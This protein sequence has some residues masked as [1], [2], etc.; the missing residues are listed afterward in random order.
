MPYL[1][2]LA[3]YVAAIA[4]G[5]AAALRGIAAAGLRAAA[6]VVTARLVA[7]SLRAATWA[8]AAAVRAAARVVIRVVDGS[9]VA[10]GN[11]LHHVAVAVVAGDVDGG[12]GQLALDLWAWGEEHTARGDDARSHVVHRS[13]ALGSNAEAH[14]AKARDG[15]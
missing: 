5:R 3:L 8:V 4:V 2:F 11:L 7:A 13:H 1:L 12:V 6:W 10:R 14:S 15:Y 9:V